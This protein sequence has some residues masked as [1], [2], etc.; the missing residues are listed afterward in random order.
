MARPSRPC[1]PPKTLVKA[2]AQRML[3]SPDCPL[4]EAQL[5]TGKDARATCGCHLPRPCYQ[6]PPD[7]CFPSWFG[8]GN[9]GPSAGPD[10]NGCSK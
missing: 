2:G 8:S 3:R 5:P 1:G 10:G 6:L 4:M 9:I 7:C